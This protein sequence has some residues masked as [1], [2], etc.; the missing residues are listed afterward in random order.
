MNTSLL[1]AV[2]QSRPSTLAP[3]GLLDRIALR[4]GITLIGWV[5]RSEQ[6]RAQR[7]ATRRQQAMRDRARAELHREL[8]RER[9]RWD[10]MLLFRSLQ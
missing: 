7:V 6:V 8:E 5:D 3:P 10:S 1:H 2:E 9:L 4:V